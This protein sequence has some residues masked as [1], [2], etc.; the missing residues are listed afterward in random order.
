MGERLKVIALQLI[1]NFLGSGNDIML[2]TRHDTTNTKTS[3][4]FRCTP[5]GGGTPG[6]G[7]A[8]GGGGTPGFGSAPQSGDTPGF[9]LVTALKLTMIDTITIQIVTVMMTIRLPMLSILTIRP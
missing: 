1:V 7:S 5:G 9:G 4:G 8:T 2:K 6:F 3:P